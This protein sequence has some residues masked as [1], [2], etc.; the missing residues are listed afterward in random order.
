MSGN[1]VR[2]VVFSVIGVFFAICFAVGQ[3]NAKHGTKIEQPEYDERQLADQLFACK[4]ALWTVVGYLILWWFMEMGVLWDHPLWCAEFGAVL[5][6]CL[7]ACVGVSICILRDAVAF[8]G[9]K[10]SANYIVIY[11]MLGMY[12]LSSWELAKDGERKLVENGMLGP[13]ATIPLIFL[14]CLF[15][16]GCILWKKRQEKR[17]KKAAAKTEG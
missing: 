15:L 16:T 10:K 2:I 14:S 13:D 9:Q 7:A 3:Y 6:L 5:G 1:T 17:E 11:Y 12:A 4:A 8:V